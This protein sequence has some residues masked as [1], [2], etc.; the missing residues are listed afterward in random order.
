MGIT[1]SLGFGQS[2]GPPYAAVAVPTT[3]IILVLLTLYYFKHAKAN[4]KEGLFFGVVLAIVGI[5]ID[6]ALMLA[7]SKPPGLLNPA[8]YGALLM[9]IVIPVIIGWL[10]GRKK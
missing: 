8:F 10:K 1:A 3:I 7:L 9:V 2:D 4:A 6:T 5:I